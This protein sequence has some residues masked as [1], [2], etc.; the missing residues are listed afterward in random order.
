MPQD[1][2]PRCH[3][4]AMALERPGTDH[5]DAQC[6]ESDE[7]SVR[8]VAW[9]WRGR[10]DEAATTTAQLDR[11]CVII[12]MENLHFVMLALPPPRSCPVCLHVALEAERERE[13]RRRG[14]SDTTLY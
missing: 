13:K 5:Y 7:R 1:A 11:R 6:E 10:R 3:N 9:V 8:C 14:S 12:C 4:T 2:T